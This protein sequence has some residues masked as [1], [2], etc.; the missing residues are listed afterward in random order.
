MKNPDTMPFLML[1]GTPEYQIDVLKKFVD[2]IPLE[3][4]SEAFERM[5]IDVPDIVD[6]AAMENRAKDFLNRYG[7]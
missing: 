6:T 4:I 7:L 1:D 2:N 5:G 3:T